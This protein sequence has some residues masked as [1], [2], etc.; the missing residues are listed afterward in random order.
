MTQPFRIGTRGSRL[1][2]WQ[3]NHIADRL[4]A[5]GSVVEL[6]I[7]Q[8]QG[9]RVQERPL[10]QIG[11]DGLFTKA[12][13]EA[14]LDHSAD[15]AVH[16]L[17]D[18]PT[19]PV[20]GLTLAAVPERAPTRDAFISRRHSRFDALPQGARVAT[21]SLRRKAQIRHR[22]PDL[23]LVE[24]RGNVDTRL[25]KLD[26][27]G[28]DGLILAEAGLQRL[29]LE[30]VI[31][32][33]L[34]QDWMVPAVGQGALGLECRSDDT[35][36]LAAL[37]SLDDAA[38]HNAVLAERAFLLALG[39][40]CLVPIGAHGRVSGNH[41]NLRGVV[42]SPDGTRRLVGE[43]D[44]AADGAVE[45]GQRLAQQLL[46]QGAQEILAASA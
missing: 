7:I 4:R 11:G 3:A 30:A 17:K 27:Q 44:G 6:V 13:Q 24:I 46:S 20:A 2:L 10:A 9:D 19:A 32:E 31:T 35:A 5:A 28:L 12:I 41:L 25:R 42:V 22:R 45:L 16:S 43:L 38:T 1:A 18:L 26:E 23:E 36:V 21:G 37:A 8:T 15:I 29:G 39:G 34:D 14:L 33:L 40:G